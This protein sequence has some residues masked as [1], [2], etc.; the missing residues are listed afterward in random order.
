VDELLGQHEIVIKP[1]GRLLDSVPGVAGT[2]EL[3]AGRAALVLDMPSLAAA[4]VD[5]PANQSRGA[6]DLA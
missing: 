4:Y 2:T 5:R 6:G 1:V 3:G